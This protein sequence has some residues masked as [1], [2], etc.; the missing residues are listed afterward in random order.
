MATARSVSRN[1][2][3]TS[4]HCD[5]LFMAGGGKPDSSPTASKRRKRPKRAT[6]R[7]RLARN[8]IFD[9]TCYARLNQEQLGRTADMSGHIRALALITMAVGLAAATSAMAQDTLETFY[10]GKTIRLLIGATVGGG[11]DAYA[12]LVG[13]HIGKY[14]PGQPTVLPSNMSGAG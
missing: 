14:I 7:K 2:P 1:W 13:R 10:R 3:G 12:R 9:G 11:Y 4:V 6:S 8:C 5:A